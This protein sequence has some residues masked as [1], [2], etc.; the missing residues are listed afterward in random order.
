[1]NTQIKRLKIKGE[2]VARYE[3]HI[4]VL[5]ITMTDDKFD[6][7]QAVKLISE[8]EKMKFTFVSKK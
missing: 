7:D 6:S 4:D 3:I 2:E 1:M 8:L 5:V